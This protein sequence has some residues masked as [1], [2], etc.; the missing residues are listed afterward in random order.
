[1]DPKD[2]WEDIDQQIA[3]HNREQQALNTQDLFL[4]MQAA[5]KDNSPW[6]VSFFGC[7]GSFIYLALPFIIFTFI[8]LFVL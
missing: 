2:F 7:I 6:Y 4:R 5:A 1:M 8:W 3:Q